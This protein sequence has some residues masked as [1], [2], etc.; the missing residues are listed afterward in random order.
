MTV[1]P[2]SKAKIGMVMEHSQILLSTEYC[3]VAR[4]APNKLDSMFFVPGRC[5]GD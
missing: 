1:F 5:K 3:R 4:I 2:A